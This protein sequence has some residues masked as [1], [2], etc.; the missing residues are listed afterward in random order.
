[1]YPGLKNTV[2]PT[3]YAEPGWENMGS[4]LSPEHKRKV[5][6]KQLSHGFEIESPISFPMR[7]T[8]KLSALPNEGAVINKKISETITK[9]MS[10][11]FI[12]YRT[13]PGL[14]KDY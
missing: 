14:S 8:I 7:I 4:Y 11:L 3:I 9:A 10:L 1:M 12:E 2:C 6:R 13:R 5:K